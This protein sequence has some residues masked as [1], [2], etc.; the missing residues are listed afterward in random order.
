MHMLLYRLAGILVIVFLMIERGVRQRMQRVAD[1]KIANVMKMRSGFVSGLLVCMLIFFLFNSVAV[2][3][4]RIDGARFVQS[5]HSD[6]SCVD[7]HSD[8]EDLDRHPDPGHVKK[9]MVDFFDAQ[10]CLECHEDVQGEIEDDAEHGG[11]PV[12]D[13][14]QF[15]NCIACHDPHYEGAPE[16]ILTNEAMPYSGDD[17]DCMTCHQAVSAEDPDAAIKNREFCF[18]C[19]V[20][21]KQMPDSVPVMDPSLYDQSPH[22]TLDCL[23]CHPQAAQY[24]HH[25][26]SVTDCGQCHARHEASVAHDAHS[27]VA[28]QACHLE[29][30][31]PVRDA[32][33]HAV[34][35]ERAAL[36]GT[37]TMLHN[38][39]QPDGQG[40]ARCHYDNN[41]VGA[42]AMVLP[43]KSV[44]CMPCHAAT[45]TAGD[46][47]TLVSLAVFAIGMLGFVAL[48]FSG[49]FTGSAGTHVVTNALQ[50]LA[51][52]FAV[53][54]SPKIGCI[55]KTLWYDVL[56]QRRLYQRSPQRWAIHALIFWPFAIR[57]IWGIAAL[58]LTTGLKDIP[59]AWVLIDKNHPATALV[60]DLTGLCLVVG[61]ILAM[62]RGSEA[63]KTRAPGLPAQDRLALILIGAIALVGFVIEGMRIAMT[64]VQGPAAFAFIG[65]G[66]SKLFSG[67][68]G[69]TEAYGYLWYLHAVLTGAFVAYLPFSRMMHIIM[70]PVVMAMNAATE[71]EHH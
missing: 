28:C 46:T 60:F 25:L 11:E 21:D 61:I 64:G 29:S 20:I 55:L 41:P 9:K 45:L 68:R 23:T 43:P 63:D 39:I 66:I 47:T 16:N 44:L 38:Y 10:S 49:S 71:K 26:Q 2:A 62:I 52:T 50:A 53:L 57:F 4:W 34:L 13:V 6:T 58:V 40:C 67:M 56:L 17:E 8:I 65:Y 30:V 7:C 48:W 36:P 31:V 19:H 54:F 69:L 22:A 24:E 35:W 1:S 59:I 32:K 15:L 14:Q 3:G 70:S 27:N 12:E 51:K 37:V 42:A 18:A 5:V 33:T